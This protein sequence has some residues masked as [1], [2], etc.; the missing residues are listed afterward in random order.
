MNFLTALDKMSLF[1]ILG[2]LGGIYPFYS[3]SNRTFCEQTVETLIRCPVLQRLIWVCSICLCPT[4]KMLGLYG[5]KMVSVKCNFLISQPKHMLLVLKRT[6]SLMVFLSIQN[7]CRPL[8]KNLRVC[9]GGIIFLFL[10]QNICCGYST[11]PSQ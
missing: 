3:N 10:K 4:I 11:E 1:Q 6:V 7:T 8:V 2:V 5:L 9:K